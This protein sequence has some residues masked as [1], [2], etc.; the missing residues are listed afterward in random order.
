[1]QW[2]DPDRELA[3]QLAQMAAGKQPAYF[4]A[5]LFDSESVHGARNRS[6][7]N[8]QCITGFC[9]DVEG[10]ESKGGYAGSDAARTAIESHIMGGPLRPSCLVSTGVGWHCWW[11][12]DEPLSV[13]EWLPLAQQIRRWVEATG[14]K[15]DGPVTTDPV[16][17]M[18]APGSLHQDTGG[19][20]QAY[21]IKGVEHYTPDQIREVVGPSGGSGEVVDGLGPVPEYLRR[22]AA[23]IN[24][25]VAA[26][27][28]RKY[29]FA[30]AA[31]S[32]PALAA[33]CRR[34]GQDTDYQNWVLMLA[35]AKHSAEG[36][37]I[38]HTFS[39]GH[40]DYDETATDAKLA[41]LTGG[42]ATCAAWGAAGGVNGPCSGC[43][44]RG[45]IKSP[46][47][48]GIMA[49]TV[50]VGE[51]GAVE[52]DAVP[53][54]VAKLNERFALVR[55]GGRVMVAD[56]QAPKVGADHSFT[57]LEFIDLGAFRALFKGQRV[58]SAD[59]TGRAVALSEY[60]ESHPARRQYQGVAFAPGVE[61]PPAVLNLWQ[62]FA[63]EPATGGVQPWLDVLRA[64]VPDEE[65]RAYVLRWLA[66]KVQ[67]PGSVPDTVLIFRGAKGAGKNAL[68]QPLLTAFGA[69]GLLVADPELI[70]G[71]FTWHLIDKAFVVL[72]EA[73]FIGDP[74]QADR[75]KARVTGAEM[76]YE[77][78]GADPVQ[79]V[80]RAAFV[81]L[82]NHGH[83]WEATSDER[84]AVVVDV[85]E[86]LCRKH[87]FWPK[88]FS[89]LRAGGA[90][91]VLHYLQGLD[92]AGFNPRKLPANAALQRQVAMTALRDPTTAWWHSCLTEGAVSWSEGGMVR[93]VTLSEDG[94]TEVPRTALR[95]S[96]QQSPGSR[97]RGASDWAQA[98]KD[99]RRLVGP[100]L[101]STRVRDGNSR[102]RVEVLPNLAVLKSGLFQATG[103][104]AD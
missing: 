18:R 35:T 91:K 96:Y 65:L 76:A 78:K 7:D 97:R 64:V 44:W 52:P 70:A 36:E 16:R 82:T 38:A 75:I 47:V 59:G 61:L 54:E 79:A 85:G 6:K 74:R 22:A 55:V 2:A 102:E 89:W 31:E 100:D 26:G 32:C 56:F 53:D 8:V 92:T 39:A 77:R 9:I 103:V 1:M 84:R 3:D 69:H 66:L 71:R 49:D 73:V 40:Q 19:V 21:R 90:A 57:G 81:M 4:T 67:Q 30:K 87:D 51:R 11:L 33:A 13:A 43:R 99:W 23:A 80:N 50:P 29:S 86:S 25:T 24:D 14:L 15:I 58:Q 45:R 41:S 12:L 63:V 10:L 60:W 48:L 68:L 62:G 17:L 28:F 88:Y 83:V 42:P 34:Q 27:S 72:D 94:S 101:H 98:S 20:V 104:T 5:A 93:S 46:V 95:M 37:A